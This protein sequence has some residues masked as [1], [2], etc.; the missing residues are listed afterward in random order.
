TDVR[1]GIYHAT[2]TGTDSHYCRRYVPI[3][4]SGCSIG[5]SNKITNLS[6]TIIEKIEND[7]RI[8]NK[9][10][11]L[12]GSFVKG[13]RDNYEIYGKNYGV[14]AAIALLVLTSNGNFRNFDP[15][16]IINNLDSIDISQPVLKV[17]RTSGLT[18][19]Q[20]KETISSSILLSGVHNI[21]Y[22]QERIFGR[23]L[24]EAIKHKEKTVFPP[25]WL[26]R[27]ITVKSNGV[28]T[29]EGDSG[30]IWFNKSGAVIA[31]GHGNL[32]TNIAIYSIGSPIHAV[33]KALNIS[34]W[35]GK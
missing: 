31:M 2:G 16:D 26:D 13:F 12:V 19:G 4:A 8:A 10:D 33:E 25:K 15:E 11:T 3:I 30:S 22:Q 21:F 1:E 6:R 23:S 29:E 27:Q 20:I 9:K 24:L 5:N 18:I 28:F 32:S 17:G 35:F 14:D 7:L 34:I